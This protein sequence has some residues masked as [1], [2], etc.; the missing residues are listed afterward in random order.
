MGVKLRKLYCDD[1]DDDDDN[2]ED[3]VKIIKIITMTTE[4]KVYK[5]HQ[6]KLK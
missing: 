3:D 6:S 4:H 2:N 5:I 1:D